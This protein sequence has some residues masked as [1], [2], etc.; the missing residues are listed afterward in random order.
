MLRK[1]GRGS[2]Q[3]FVSD[4]GILLVRWYD[5]KE[6]TVGSNLFPAN[7]VDTV[8]RW[9][10]AKQQYEVVNRPACIKAYNVGMGGV[11]RCDQLLAFYRMQTKGPKWYRRV[12]FHFTDL[13]IVNSFILFKTITRN[14]GLESY[15]FKLEVANALMMGVELCQPLSRSALILQSADVPRAENGDPIAVLVV[16][17]LVRLD[18]QDHLPEAV[19]SKARKCKIKGCS[20]RTV[21]WCTKCRVYLCI[22]PSKNCFLAFHTAR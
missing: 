10:R 21:T 3:S 13:S 4:D 18:R 5:N 15:K 12:L 22:K 17:D 2:H 1:E 20:S 16:N 11:D 19:A 8:R 9:S 6:V 14:P 7:P